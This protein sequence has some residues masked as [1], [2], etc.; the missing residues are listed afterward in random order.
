MN[1]IAGF[2]GGYVDRL[3]VMELMG[4]GK[5]RALGVVELGRHGGRE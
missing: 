3:K 2:D 1:L 4:R 5:P